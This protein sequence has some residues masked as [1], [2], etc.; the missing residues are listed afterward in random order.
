[1]FYHLFRIDFVS[2]FSFRKVPAFIFS[3]SYMSQK[4]SVS[5]PHYPSLLLYSL[6]LDMNCLIFQLLYP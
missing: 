3:L 6:Y 5:S 4:R 2:F 1:M